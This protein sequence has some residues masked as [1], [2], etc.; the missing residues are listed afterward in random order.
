[1]LF[2]RL[3]ARA[4]RWRAASSFAVFA[5]AVVAVLAAVIGPIYLAAA[6][7]VVL[8]QRL[9]QAP[10]AELDLHV[11]RTSLALNTA[12]DL[13]ADVR[14]VAAVAAQTPWFGPTVVAQT[15]QV[16]F[17]DNRHV[18]AQAN[19]GTVDGYCSHLRF[20]AGACPTEPGQAAVS[21]REAAAGRYHVGSVVHAKTLKGAQELKLRI[22]GIYQPVA[23][24]GAYWSA[25]TFFDAH[26]ALFTG[27]AAEAD[28][29][30]VSSS[31]MAAYSR[32]FDLDTR[33]DVPFLPDQVRIND[34]NAV[35]RTVAAAAA[36]AQQVSLG[37][38]FAVTAK[39]DAAAH[40]D[41]IDHE[42]SLTR[43]LVNLATLQLAL[44]VICVLYALV[45][46][47]STA[48][49]NEVALAKLRG[50]RWPAVLAQGLLEPVLLVLLAA[51]AGA[52]LAWVLVRAVAPHT[53]GPLA[54]V[55]FPS[56]ALL[57]TVLTAVAAVIA[58]ALAARRIVT[59][60][61]GALL[62]R[63]N[64]TETSRVWLFVADAAA[65]ALALAGLFQLSA[66]GVLTAGKP[67]ALS[68][69]APT[70]L[71]VA[72]GVVGLRLLP[73]GARAV[74]AATR[75][76][77]RLVPFLAVR[78]ILR[79]ANSTRLALLV[80][81]ALSLATLAVATWSVGGTNRDIRALTE[82]GAYRVLFVSAPSNGADLTTAVD[83]ADPGGQNAMAV[84]ILPVNNTPLLAMEAQR[85]PGI[86]AWR[87]DFSKASLSQIVH[88]LKPQLP[89]SLIVSGTTVRV[90]LTLDTLTPGVPLTAHVA[91]IQPSHQLTTLDLGTVQSGR[92]DYSATLPAGCK[93]GC[94]IAE[95]GFGTRGN[96]QAPF[97]A[98][99]PQYAPDAQ[100]ELNS[101]NGASSDIAAHY[102]AAP[103]LWRQ[104]GDAGALT[105][106]R[107]EHGLGITASPDP[108]TTNWPG[109]VPNDVPDHLP[110]LLGK[111][112]AA[113]YSGEAIHDISLL[114]L[115]GNSVSAD[116]K[117]VGAILPRLGLY[118][119]IADLGLVERG[120]TS[121]LATGV[122]HEVWLSPHAPADIEK[123]L[124]AQG[125][126]ITGT[127]SQ[128]AHRKVLDESG[129]AY[130]DLVFLLAALAASVLAI[131]GAVLAGV[132]TARRRSYELAALEAVGV[133]PRT[134]RWASAVEQGMII[135]L[136]IVFGV[137]AGIGG[138][139]MALP[140]TP[141]FVDP[142]N[143]PP[144]EFGLPWPLLL[145][146]IA[147]VVV[148]LAAVCLLMARAIEGQATATRLRET[149]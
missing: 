27:Q 70:L 28:T 43:T 81:V 108:G 96:Y 48:H 41:T 149:Q 137:V 40:L 107:D 139:A 130:A 34:E 32:H 10:R 111:A 115:D 123:R 11:E 51:P 63:G 13:T 49:G 146:L 99:K 141:I 62:R 101:V 18:G 84:E 69:L 80:A 38:E 57:I 25:W 22:A 15:V 72:V 85:M 129:P 113:L 66:G 124:E 120:M 93:A 95:I 114:G 148:V 64:E 55:T 1:M 142:Q 89:P 24:N 118:G 116:G 144:I 77:R 67:N 138:S 102:L 126:R 60:P 106:A 82:A 133:R 37:Q 50:R 9:E 23:P 17:F 132:V 110:V 100:L 56:S 19:V 90:G 105:V 12:F 74:L 29:F 54:D 47:T 36:S 44:L 45:S 78:Q 61:V 20:S 121:P 46:A 6:S 65:L 14:S 5:V 135:G 127:D 71:A 3:L 2:L 104:G 53:L 58:A 147:A 145:L 91:V 87:S 117:V 73:F 30:F 97:D 128:A 26:P 59:A 4:L 122:V 79:R 42:L 16:E 68:A 88:T 143:A 125:L 33:A 112:S 94:R 8:T 109:L 131:G 119:A 134:L 35:R 31:A 136:G 140:S 39:S 7:Q 83:R 86:A 75:E 52:A 98:R 76:S 92:H 103:D 21:A